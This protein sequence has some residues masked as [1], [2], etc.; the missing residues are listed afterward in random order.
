MTTEPT[1][2]E[3][4]ANAL[5]PKDEP[6]AY[7]EVPEYPDKKKKKDKKKSAEKNP[8]AVNGLDA[9]QLLSDVLTKEILADGEAPP[10]VGAKHPNE[11]AAPAK[12][13]RLTRTKRQHIPHVRRWRGLPP[14]KKK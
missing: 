6:K 9:E 3:I 4:A 14:L 12:K 2:E 11:V 5:S 8:D 7:G 10:E 1:M 13:A